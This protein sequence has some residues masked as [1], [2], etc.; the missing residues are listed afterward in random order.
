MIYELIG[1][2][3]VGFIR[4]RYGRE[5]RI[6]AGTGLALTALGVGAYLASRGGEDEQS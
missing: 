2:M 1:R 6:A 5:L 4:W 3:V